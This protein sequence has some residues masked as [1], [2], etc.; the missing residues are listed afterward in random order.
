MSDPNEVPAAGDR[1]GDE[2][3][4]HDDETARWRRIVRA[5]L[6]APR[7]A[8]VLSVLAQQRG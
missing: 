5:W 4:T 8:A 3:M 1:N 6:L 2:D 7:H